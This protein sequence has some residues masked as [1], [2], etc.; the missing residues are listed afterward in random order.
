MDF[1]SWLIGFKSERTPMNLSSV[2]DVTLK[3]KLTEDGLNQEREECEYWSAKLYEISF[4]AN[5]IGRM[6]HS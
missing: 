4:I 1:L 5:I 3:M 6:L 2:S